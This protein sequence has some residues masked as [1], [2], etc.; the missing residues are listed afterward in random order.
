MGAVYAATDES[1]GTP[2]AIKVI[3][4]HVARA[5][6]NAERFHREVTLA[7]QVGHPGIVAVLDAGHDP[8]FGLFLVMEL[9]S[10]VTLRLPLSQGDLTVAQAVEV[11]AATL[12]ALHAAHSLGIVHR[13]LK[14]DNIFLHAPQ[15]GAPQVKLLDFGVA[16]QRNAA[17]LTMTN[18][19]VG[20]PHF[21]AP[22]QATDARSVTPASD[23]WSAGVM[24]YY[25]LSGALPYDGDGPYDTVL[26]ACTAKH[27]PLDQRAPHV[28]YRL[29]D[30]V[31]TCLEKDP[32]ERFQDAGELLEVLAPLV[33]EPD[34]QHALS[35][36]V[37]AEP[38]VDAAR[39]ESSLTGWTPT[40]EATPALQP[41]G[42]APA[43]SAYRTTVASMT[44][45]QP[46]A[47]GASISSPMALAVETRS[48]A[49]L[50]S[51]SEPGSRS[52]QVEGRRSGARLALGVAVVV[53]LAGLATASMQWRPPEAG[54]SE[55]VAGPAVEFGEPPPIA[56]IR[57]APVNDALNGEEPRTEHEDAPSTRRPV[58]S[59]GRKSVD[60]G[61]PTDDRP[62]RVRGNKRVAAGDRVTERSRRAGASGPA[63]IRVGGDSPGVRVGGSPSAGNAAA[64]AVASSSARA[65]KA[66]RG[67]LSSEPAETAPRPAVADTVP[68][69]VAFDAP[70]QTATQ[71]ATQIV[72]GRTSNTSETTPRVSTSPASSNRA[73]VPK[74]K[75]KK[76][77]P[78]A[79]PNKEVEPEFVTF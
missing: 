79:K 21:M 78:I 20:T 18:V 15:D 53:L 72:M 60:R 47:V 23:V 34:L 61:R 36:R 70:V 62:S 9:L 29:V 67:E 12:D 5:G 41:S 30:I 56:L 40:S 77:E 69:S 7:Q 28:D 57:D 63:Q 22:E 32:V 52:G 31:E 17:G 75:T 74:S 37:A 39:W 6:V 3:H 51:T 59:T 44:G 50:T 27:V 58:P 13:D 33:A 76:A 55:E 24:L 35:V 45:E 49:P 64:A 38:M 54:I 43:S 48:P 19:G 4:P 16:R 73:T 11:V 8:S 71:T 66:E 68:S 2:C 10:G 14:P 46:A 42:P 26:R 25:V 65:V 1:N